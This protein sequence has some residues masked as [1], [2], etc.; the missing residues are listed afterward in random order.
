MV[1]NSPIAKF[2]ILLAYNPIYFI[3]NMSI[4]IIKSHFTE[5]ENNLI[6]IENFYQFDLFKFYISDVAFFCLQ[7]AKVNLKFT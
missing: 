1:I 7:D 5:L 6:E 3:T 4:Y 2:G